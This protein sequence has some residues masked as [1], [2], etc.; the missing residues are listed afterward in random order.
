M[1]TLVLGLCAALTLTASAQTNP[2]ERALLAGL[3]MQHSAEYRALCLQAYQAA[4]RSLD[5]ALALQG[6]RAV[7][8]ERVMEDGRPR[9]VERPMAV[10]MDLDETVID[11]SGYQSYLYLSGTSF[12]PETWS[13]WLAFQAREPR[14]RR[15]VPGAVEFV[16]HAE[17][18]GVKVFYISN[19]PASGQEATASLLEQLGVQRPDRDRLRLGDKDADARAAAVWGDADLLTRAQGSK[20]RRRIEVQ[21]ENHVVEYLGDD[22]ADFLPYVKA[23]D[24][25]AGRFAEVE[26]NRD[27]WGTC[28]FILPNPMYGS[29]QEQLP[30]DPTGLV[31]DFGFS[32]IL[33][34]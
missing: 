26:Q 32:K 25:E 12:K 22:L 21:V 3:W 24:V 18:R 34:P 7:V 4:T 30:K 28:W 5:D 13:A 17:S 19:R 11:N 23:G 2:N 16:R 8:R 29:W 9:W 10:I 31:D 20:E 1:K 27:R 14:A 6:G 15:A 33:A